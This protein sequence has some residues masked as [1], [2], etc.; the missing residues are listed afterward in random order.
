MLP[1]IAGFGAAARAAVALV[2]QAARLAQVRDGM[3]RACDQRLN[4]T[5]II[6][7][8][9]STPLQ[10]VVLGGAGLACGIHGDQVGPGQRF[11]ISGFGVLVG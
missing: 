10:Y 6:G 9:A 8:D 1:A 4:A 2:D 5:Q 3:E 11:S 7:R